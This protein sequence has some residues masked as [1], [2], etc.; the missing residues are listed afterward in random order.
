MIPLKTFIPYGSYETVNPK[1]SDYPAL[2]FTMVKPHPHEL[3]TLHLRMYWVMWADAGGFHWMGCELGWFPVSVMVTRI[4]TSGI[5]RL[6]RT[7]C[8]CL[9]WIETGA[10]FTVRCSLNQLD[11][12]WNS[13]PCKIRWWKGNLWFVSCQQKHKIHLYA[14][15]T[16]LS[17][18]LLTF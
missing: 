4:G 14:F 9:S 2:R 6:K 1:R 5:K 10:R 8:R 7:N 17:C 3:T 18:S 15:V 11:F 12:F 13:S 16:F